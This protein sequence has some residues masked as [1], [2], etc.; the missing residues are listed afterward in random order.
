MS[1]LIRN[2]LVLVRAI[3]NPTKAAFAREEL[4]APNTVRQRSNWNSLF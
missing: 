2:A 1:E 4:M 3:P